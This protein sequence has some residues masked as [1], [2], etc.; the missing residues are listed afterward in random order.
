MDIKKEI[1]DRLKLLD[2]KPKHV[3]KCN[4]WGKDFE[5]RKYR[6]GRQKTCRE[7]RSKKR[8]NQEWK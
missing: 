3:A 6:Y 4:E 1:M 2:P 7:C 5:Y 8:P